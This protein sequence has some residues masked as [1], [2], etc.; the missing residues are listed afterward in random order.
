MTVPHLEKRDFLELREFVHQH[1][2][3][4]LAEA[5]L[6]MVEQRLRPMVLRGGYGSFRDFIEGSLR[7]P[8]AATLTDLVNRITTNHTYF[9]REPEHFDF[10]VKTVLPELAP[11][12]QK[13]AGPGQKPTFRMWCAAASR[14][15]EPYTLAMLQREFWGKEYE[16]WDAGLL[17]TDISEQALAVAL[18]GRY[19]E[20]EVSALPAALR[21][22]WFLPRSGGQREVRP[23]LRRDVCYRRFNLHSTTYPFRR[24]FDVIFCRN[25]LIYFDPPT[26]L[27]VV[28]R[29]ARKLTPG[30]Y[31]FVGL[32]ESLGRE[33]SSLRYLRPGVYQKPGG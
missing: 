22:R 17:A 27:A 13:A 19:P 28:D 14:G 29:L 9:H 16:R 18:A 2:G 15:H 30:G 31:L 6:G 7:H 10:L 26:K 11:R 4:H 8:S 3:I 25:V 24:P 5:K 23:E 1:L 33:V 20:D 21:E 12:L 32:A